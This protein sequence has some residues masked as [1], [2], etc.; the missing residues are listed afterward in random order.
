VAD[1]SRSLPPRSS[2]IGAGP[3]A[4]TVSTLMAKIEAQR[5]GLGVGF[6]PKHR[7]ADELRE[8][9]LVTLTVEEPRDRTRLHC[10]WRPR[11]SGKALRWWLA[12]LEEANVRE[13][14]LG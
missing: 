8:G 3:E 1:S 14:L 2:G 12:C 7:I 6:L 5:S 13:A 4:L 9:R 10:L 11:D